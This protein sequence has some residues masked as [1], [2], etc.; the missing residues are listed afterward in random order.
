MFKVTK[1]ENIYYVVNLGDNWQNNPE[2]LDDISTIAESGNPVIL[3]D[4]ISDLAKLHIDS[5]KY[6]DDEDENE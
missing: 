5:V 1:A 6:I 3:V 4:K 2:I